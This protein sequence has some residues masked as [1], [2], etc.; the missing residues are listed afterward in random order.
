M[1]LFGSQPLTSTSDIG[2]VKCKDCDK[3]VLRSFMAE[4]SG[5]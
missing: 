5:F 2:L 4:H 1:K 3:P